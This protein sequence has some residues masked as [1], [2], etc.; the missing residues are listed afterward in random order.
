MYNIMKG[1]I[2]PPFLPLSIPENIPEK[3]PT[4]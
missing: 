1:L 2:D 4:I 3:V